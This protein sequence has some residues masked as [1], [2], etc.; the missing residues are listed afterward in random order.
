MLDMEDE[1]ERMCRNISLTKGEKVGITVTDGE[2]EEIREKGT[3]CLVGKLL[4][5][6][7][8]NKE[9]FKVVLSRIWCTVG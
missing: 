8:V 3:T 5:E 4:A 2:V 1:L 6:N 7:I 9:A